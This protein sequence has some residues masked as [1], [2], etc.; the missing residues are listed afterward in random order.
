MTDVVVMG[1]G[2]EERNATWADSRR[3]YDASMGLRDVDDLHDV[4]EFFEA[5]NGR[6]IG[7]RWKDWAD[8]RSGRPRST[9]QPGDQSLGIGDGLQ[10]DFQ[11][12]KTYTSGPRSY[13]RA[14]TK[15]VEGT[16]RVEV[17][18]IELSSGAFSVDTTT[19]TVSLASPPGVGTEV[20]AGYEFD[21][22]VRFDADYISVSIDAFK[23]GSVPQIDV[24]EVKV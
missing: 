24:I 1:S 17:G 11:L 4:L 3:R 22:P 7:F 20:R 12:Q 21:V 13:V 6:L 8:H 2:F 19:G 10:T 9:P 23:A 15:P 5:R 18:G 16:V 14:V